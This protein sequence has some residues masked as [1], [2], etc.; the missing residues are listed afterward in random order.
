MNPAGIAI[1][2]IGVL[3]IVQV[4]MGGALTRLR[5]IS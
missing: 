5:V 4:T 3:V 2:I 1:A